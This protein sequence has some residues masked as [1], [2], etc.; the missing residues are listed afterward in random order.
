[1]ILRL[2][3]RPLQSGS[4]DL[5]QLLGYNSFSGIL[6]HSAV[7]VGCLVIGLLRIFQMPC[8][9]ALLLFVVSVFFVDFFVDISSF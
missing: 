5:L 3:L 8:S 7:T 9:A 4:Q 6:S 1:M 2:P